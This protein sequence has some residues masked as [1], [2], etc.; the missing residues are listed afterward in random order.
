MSTIVLI[1][2]AVIGTWL[3]GNIVAALMLDHL[4][5]NRGGRS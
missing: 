1:A 5:R 2:I 3:A 4:S